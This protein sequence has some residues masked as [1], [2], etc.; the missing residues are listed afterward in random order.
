MSRVVVAY[1]TFYETDQ[2]FP[3]FFTILHSHEQ[4]RRVPVAICMSKVCSR[5][6]DND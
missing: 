2:L 1:L 3:S 4:H 6:K 5:E